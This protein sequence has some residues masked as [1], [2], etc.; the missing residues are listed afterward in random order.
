ML[1]LLVRVTVGAGAG[2]GSASSSVSSSMAVV[3]AV[4]CWGVSLA[5]WRGIL[6]RFGGLR[7]GDGGVGTARSGWEELVPW[8]LW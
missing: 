5:L 7:E 6:K 4:V 3:M 1:N 2:S 8:G